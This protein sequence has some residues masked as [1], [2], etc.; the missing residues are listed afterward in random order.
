[1]LDYKKE[2][3]RFSKKSK[4]NKNVVGTN[5]YTQNKKDEKIKEIGDLVTK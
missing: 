4:N 3:K 5:E 2:A 1:M